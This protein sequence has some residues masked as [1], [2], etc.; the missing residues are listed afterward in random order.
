[1]GIFGDIGSFLGS[2][3]GPL[4]TLIG[5]GLGSI[6]DLAT[7]QSI[8]PPGFIG[9]GSDI[10]GSIA[11]S[12]NNGQPWNEQLPI[13]PGM[14]PL[15]TGTVFGSGDTGGFIFSLSP[16][17]QLML[18]SVPSGGPSPLLS[19][20]GFLVNF[21]TGTGPRNRYYG[22]A[23]YRTVDL[24]RSKG[25]Q[26]NMQRI[27]AA[28]QAGQTSGKV[29]LGTAQGG[30]NLPYDAVHSPVG[31]QVGGYAGGTWTANGNTVTMTIP[32]DAGAKSFLYHI[33]PN[34]PFSIGP[35]RTINQ[36]FDITVANPCVG[37]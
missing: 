13:G 2:F 18:G 10:F 1:L 37:H 31:V 27:T 4:G 35:G 15:N 33:F 8:S 16:D 14:G 6:G 19:T 32:N 22:P 17:E 5:W 9:I 24:M 23:D 34:S 26:Q 30:L 12:V 11:G 7:G 36:K 20:V 3:F 28:C 25:F 29:E 21:L